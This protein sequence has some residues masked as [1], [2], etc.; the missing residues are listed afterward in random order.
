M[1]SSKYSSTAIAFH[2]THALIVL[3]MVIWGAWMADLPKGPERGEAFALHKSVGILAFM[4][5]LA[6]LTWRMFH[7]PPPSIIESKPLRMLSKTIH[8]LL[9]LFLLIVPLAGYTSASF[10]KY[11]MKF[12]GIPFPKFGWEDAGLNEFFS[13]THAVLAWSFVALIALHILGAIFHS[14]SL[15]RMWFFQTDKG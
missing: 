15:K 7:T 11:D 12:F 10:T 5:L 9:Y 1:T 4:L 14:Q 13:Q 2:W 8:G 3:F 6:R